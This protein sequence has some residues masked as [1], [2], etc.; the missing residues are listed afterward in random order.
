[1]HSWLFGTS[2]QHSTIVLRFFIPICDFPETLTLHISLYF[3]KLFTNSLLLGILVFGLLSLNHVLKESYNMEQ[4]MC[5]SLFSSVFSFKNCKYK[6]VS[7]LYW[8]VHFNMLLVAFNSC[9]NVY[10]L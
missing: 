10:F 7:S 9:D 1:R 2:G 6:S 3:L 4:C 8:S 5:P